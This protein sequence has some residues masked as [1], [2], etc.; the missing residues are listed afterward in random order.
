MA[1][2]PVALVVAAVPP[3]SGCHLL[4]PVIQKMKT[5]YS[6]FGAGLIFQLGD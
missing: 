6:L 3:A 2:V 1:V 4:L 5:S